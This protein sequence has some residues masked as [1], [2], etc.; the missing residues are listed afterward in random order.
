MK[1]RSDWEP[2]PTVVG[3][4][5]AALPGENG[6][7]DVLHVQGID[8]AEDLGNLLRVLDDKESNDRP[9]VIVGQYGT[10][11]RHGLND[12]ERLIGKCCLIYSGG[13]YDLVAIEPNSG[14]EWQSIVWVEYI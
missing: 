2:Q 7:P 11:S 3:E 4:I 9:F 10:L 5:V 14:K 6:K 13:K 8:V 12:A 1:K